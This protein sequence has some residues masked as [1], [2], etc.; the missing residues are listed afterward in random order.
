V[1]TVTP[2][3]LGAGGTAAVFTA[4][5]TTAPSADQTENLVNDLR[6]SVIPKAVAGTDLTA[7]VGGQTA[8]YI[9]LAEKIADKLPQMIA[10]VVALT[11]LVLML[12][13][14]S[15]VIPVKAAVMN[16]LSVAAAYGIVTFIFQQGHAIGLV[17]LPHAIPI[18]SFA[19]LFMFAILFGLSMDYEVFLVS[20]IQ[21][22]YHAS[23]DAREAVVE[24]LAKTGRVIT[25]AALVMVFVFSSFVLNGDPVVKEFGL[26]LAV[27][28]A[29]DAT[30]VRCVLVP[31]VMELLGRASWWLPAWLQRVLPNLNVEGAGVFEDGGGARAG[32][33]PAA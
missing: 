21:E 31:S 33:A 27:A 8:G 13:F 2:P 18:V 20:Q 17:G 26:G 14:R 29:L 5:A 22:S 32:S 24:G 16:L 6:D 23:D 30:V 3:T 11:F 1:K 19:P 10:I 12:A 15:L 28:I 4:V 7:Y 25:S 9:D